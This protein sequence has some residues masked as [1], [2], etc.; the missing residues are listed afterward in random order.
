MSERLWVIPVPPGPE[1]EIPL[2]PQ[3]H[4]PMML[5]DVQQGDRDLGPL[6]FCV[7]DDSSTSDY[8]DEC[9]EV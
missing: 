3:G 5:I 6:W 1:M 2:C 8:C 7:N 4:G 9:L